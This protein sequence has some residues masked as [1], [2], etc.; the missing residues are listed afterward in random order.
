MSKPQEGQDR[1]IA[2]PASSAQNGGLPVLPPLAALGELAV[3][4]GLIY[5]LD[6]LFPQ[7]NIF[8]IEP[9][10]FW[11]PL[12]LLSLQYGT[13]SGLV[14]AGVAIAASMSAGLPEAGIGENHFAYF[15]RVWGQP[16][17][18]IAIA[19]LVGQFRMRQIAAKNELRRRNEELSRQRDALAAH[20]VDLR[21]RCE[22]LER[23]LATSRD[24]QP[25]N[26]LTA[27]GEVARGSAAARGAASVHGA[28]NLQSV[29][30]V[31]SRLAAAAFPD[32]RLV[33]YR[34]TPE[35]LSRAAVHP[36]DGEA[37]R[38]ITVPPLHPLHKA[39]V[40]RAKSL[41][42]LDR[43]DEA[44][45]G[46]IALAA[47]PVRDAVGAVAGMLALEAGA[48]DLIA[49][50]GLRALETLAAAIGGSSNF[51]TD[52]TATG[53]AMGA[54]GPAAAQP[55]AGIEQQHR[56]RV[57]MMTN[58]T[59]RPSPPAAAASPANGN[60]PVERGGAA[61]PHIRTTASAER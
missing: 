61:A 36:E 47:V 35:G 16:I 13:V 46:G 37:G 31:L 30:T 53:A 55:P 22:R 44:V 60:G 39:L 11:F 41:S 42:L 34:S 18:W 57:A 32:A 29:Q 27:L 2:S 59:L 23:A 25:F 4:F 15:L 58:P 45:L 48:P 12:L 14:A 3:A 33:V 43:R 21:E 19:L 54:H 50:R 52:G 6:R 7:F 40:E 8:E 38:A 17:L 10:P 1:P 51:A 24:A 20:A 9:H 49:P 28:Q 26:V 5:G 56:R